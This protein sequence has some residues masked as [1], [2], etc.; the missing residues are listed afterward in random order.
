MR[1]AGSQHKDVEACTPTAALRHKRG[2][3]ML[4][5]GRVTSRRWSTLFLKTSTVEATAGAD[6]YEHMSGHH[7]VLVDSIQ[8]SQKPLCS[9]ILQL[10]HQMMY[11]QASPSRSRPNGAAEM[12]G[13]G[14]SENCGGCTFLW[15][16]D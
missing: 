13:F 8:S 10:T 1:C 3:S 4:K 14:E 5:V 12:R 11:P 2:A 15:P 7:V 16:A 6:S 9:F